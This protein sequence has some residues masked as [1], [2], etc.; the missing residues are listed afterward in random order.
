[1]TALTKRRQHYLQ[2][3]TQYQQINI[4]KTTLTKKQRRHNKNKYHTVKQSLQNEDHKEYQTRK[5]LKKTNTAQSDQI[6]YFSMRLFLLLQ[7]I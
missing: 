1:M 6:R 7:P 3:Q 5:S 4:S 2:K